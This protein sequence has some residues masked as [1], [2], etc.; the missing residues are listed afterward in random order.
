M[1]IQPS[2]KIN[3]PTR[4][5]LLITFQALKFRG[6][7]CSKELSQKE[8]TKYLRNTLIRKLSSPNGGVFLSLWKTSPVHSAGTTLV[9]DQD[10]KHFIQF[11]SAHSHPFSPSHIFF[12]QSQQNWDCSN[13]HPCILFLSPLFMNFNLVL[14]ELLPKRIL[15]VNARPFPAH[16][17]DKIYLRCLVLYRLRYSQWPSNVIHGSSDIEKYI[18]KAIVLRIWSFHFVHHF[19]FVP[20]AK[21]DRKLSFVARYFITF[22]FPRKLIFFILLLPW[23]GKIF[24]KMFP[25]CVFLINFIKTKDAQHLEDTHTASHSSEQTME[26]V[27]NYLTE[28][29][30]KGTY[31]LKVSQISKLISRSCWNIW[32]KHASASKKCIKDV[33]ML[34]TKQQTD[35]GLA[36]IR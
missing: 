25:K 22:I 8:T 28:V 17:G 21:S 18:S 24:D 13:V 19:P 14:A 3:K 15:S 9:V 20:R 31:T 30:L 5:D 27:T 6:I 34:L 23:L 29:C 32:S 7:A 12:S 2:L 16:V 10:S 33:G 1:F 36:L 11:F 4:I 26:S 35:Q